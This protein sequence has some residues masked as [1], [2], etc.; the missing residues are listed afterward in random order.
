ML[1]NKIAIVTS[2]TR[3][4][5]LASAKKLAEN[6]A[7]VYLAVRRP[8][9]GQEI[10]KDIEQNGGK[11]YVVFFDTAVEE[12]YMTSIQEVGEKEGHID[13]LVNN[14]G[15]TDVKLDLDIVTGDAQ[16]F[17]HIIET[18]LKSVYLPSKAVIPYMIKSGGGSIVNISSVGGK[19]PDVTRT[20][21]GVSKSA[22]LFL[23]KDIATQFARHQVRCNAI[24][25][26]F[27]ETDAAV[28]NMSD[29]FL[30]TFLKAIPLAR[31]GRPE[32]IANAVLFLA[33]E[34]SSYI[35]GE[36]IEV[37][38]GFGMPSPMYPLY[39]SLNKEG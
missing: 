34:M 32:D 22:I 30:Q 14:F 31:S 4:I 3:G 19:Y 2:S 29:E 8:E 21:Y 15:M 26:G 1:K 10:V 27:I 20:A 16:T 24:L 9:F 33:S 28:K 18:N 35:T 12:S 11:A 5:G 25:P 23:T 6:G 37:A 17:F 13:I 36:T 39:P 7:K 38:G